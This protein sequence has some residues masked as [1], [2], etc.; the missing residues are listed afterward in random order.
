MLPFIRKNAITIAGVILGLV[1]GYLYWQFIGCASGT[2]A[3]QSD[4]W[5]MTPYGGLMG[6]L[7]ANLLQDMLRKK[8]V[9]KNG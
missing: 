8:K 9:N 1:G 4:P 6:G 5:K 7:T 3:I 2:C